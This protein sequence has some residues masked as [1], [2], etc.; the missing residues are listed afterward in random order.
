[1]I[2]ATKNG[3]RTFTLPKPLSEIGENRTRKMHPLKMDFGEVKLF[4]I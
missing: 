4:T 2:V 3:E 1:M